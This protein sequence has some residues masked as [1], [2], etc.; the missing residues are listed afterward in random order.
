VARVEVEIRRRVAPYQ[1]L[2]TRLAEIPGVDEITS[3]TIVAE[4]GLDMEV[5]ETPER[6]AS[7]AALCPGNRES[8]GKRKSGKTRKGNRYIRRALVQVAWAVSHSKDTYLR[9]KFWR[10][11]GRIG[12]KKAALA[13]AH[14]VLKVIFLMIRDQ[15][16]YQEL[17]GTFYDRMDPI[18]TK[19]KLVNRLKALGYE[20]TLT[21]QQVLPI[22]P[23]QARGNLSTC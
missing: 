11:A 12:K 10:L 8:G 14:Y 20:V 7:W 17:G 13:V 19:N 23:F 2:I 3:W 9:A 16:H 15:A 22:D 4:L 5:F 18:R 1:E 6:A 21:P